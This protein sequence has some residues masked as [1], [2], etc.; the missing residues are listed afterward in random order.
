VVE[1]ADGYKMKGFLPDYGVEME[2]FDTRCS[3]SGV[4]W[5]IISIYHEQ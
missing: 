5:S 1:V 4:L 3:R 2:D